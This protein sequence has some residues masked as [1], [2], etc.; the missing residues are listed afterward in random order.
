MKCKAGLLAWG[1]ELLVS[2]DAMLWP[3]DLD[4]RLLFADSLRV[5]HHMQIE[6]G[7][8]I[9]SSGGT[10]LDVIFIKSGFMFL[11]GWPHS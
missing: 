11:F 2:L 4:L 10:R 9:S 1:R 3:K 6:L 5:A 7:V 8:Y